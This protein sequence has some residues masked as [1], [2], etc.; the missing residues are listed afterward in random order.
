VATAEGNG[1]VAALDHALRTALLA[2]Y[3]ELDS[4]HLT[5]YKVR[6]LDSAKGTGAVVRVLLDA[7]DGDRTWSTIGV[8]ENIIQAS[9]QALS[10]SIV[11]ALLHAPGVA[12]S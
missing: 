11:F 12:H 2:V 5:D 6:I 3:P 8:S 9:W 7:T 1:P 4:I 10:E